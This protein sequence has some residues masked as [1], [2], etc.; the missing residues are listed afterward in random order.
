MLVGTTAA[1]AAA[2]ERDDFDAAVT[3]MASHGPDYLG[4]RD[5]GVGVRPG[6]YLRWGRLRVSSG[7]GWAARR[8]DAELRGLGI[9]LT[10]TDTLDISLGLR[11]DSGRRE[12]ASPALQGMGDVKRTLRARLGVSWRFRPQW[13]LGA[14]WTIDGLSRGGGS[15]VEV[16]VKH[17]WPLAEGV[18][19]ETGAQFAV[20]GS[21]YMQSYF[22]VTPEQ[23]ARSGYAVYTLDSGVRDIAWYT[24]LKAELGDDWVFIGG[25][26]W[27]RVV[28]PA[29]RSPLTQRRAAWTVNLGVGYRF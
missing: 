3:L 24:S 11:S 2:S 18:L 19:L 12:S 28:G 20:A 6:F 16:K 14:Q 4:A 1:H 15:L 29:A 22:G 26:G 27:S 8:E 13:Q 9:E 17:E 21:R 5:S 10:H 7:G 23:A 25:P